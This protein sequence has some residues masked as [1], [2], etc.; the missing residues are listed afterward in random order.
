MPQLRWPV[1]KGVCGSTRAAQPSLY[2]GAPST[3]ARQSIERQTCA[4]VTWDTRRLRLMFWLGPFA[5]HDLPQR[6]PRGPDCLIFTIY[7][8][9]D[10]R[11][12][13]PTLRSRMRIIAACIRFSLVSV[14][15]FRPLD[16][17][18]TVAARSTA[19]WWS[20]TPTGKGV[21]S[22]RLHH[23]SD[24]AYARTSA[25][26]SPRLHFR[27][28]TLT[29]LEALRER[30]IKTCQHSQILRS[31]VFTCF[32]HGYDVTALLEA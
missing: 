21:C 26:V 11:L 10:Q 31:V 17:T 28:P 32:A 3:T 14:H 16:G 8:Y 6:H 29:S 30:L 2:L 13:M 25:S 5:D 27:C 1:I 4:L 20:C 24:P 19:T 9:F 18:L 23:V 12:C 7:I 22:A 15:V